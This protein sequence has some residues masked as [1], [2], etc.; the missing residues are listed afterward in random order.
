MRRSEIRDELL[1]EHRDLRARVEASRQMA[2]RLLGH[3]AWEE[4]AFLDG[5]VLPDD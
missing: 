4:R 5:A 1:A 2:E 3:M